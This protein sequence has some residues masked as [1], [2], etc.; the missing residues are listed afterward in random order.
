MTPAWVKHDNAC[1]YLALAR[2]L[3]EAVR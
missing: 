2:P 3:G 1:V